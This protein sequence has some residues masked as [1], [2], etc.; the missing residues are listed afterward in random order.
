MIYGRDN[1]ELELAVAACLEYTGI[2]LD[3]LY[4][5]TVELLECRND[6]SFLAG[7]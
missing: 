4:T 1:V 7:T 6:T 2:D 3:L 5:R